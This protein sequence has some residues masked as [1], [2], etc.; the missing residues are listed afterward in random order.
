MRV[1][2]ICLSYGQPAP[3][4][5]LGETH[6]VPPTVA[7]L[8]AA[9]MAIVT[10][11]NAAVTVAPSAQVAASTHGSPALLSSRFPAAV[12]F[13]DSAL[14]QPNP[15]FV[16]ALLAGPGDVWHAGLCLGMSGLP[17]IID[18]VDPVWRFNRDPRPDA[19]AVSW[20][21]SLRAC[22]VRAEVVRRLG[23]PDPAFDTLTGA[24]LEMGHR[25]IG[26]GAMMRH[27]PG[28]LPVTV[29]A[30][31]SLDLT[32]ADEFRFVR[33][34]Y[35]RVW[36]AWAA[37]RAVGHGASPIET[38]RTWRAAP[39]AA[40]P[41][42]T[43]HS[44]LA[45][46]SPFA[47]EDANSAPGYAPF[48]SEDANSASGYTPFASEDAN[49]AVLH[50]VDGVGH[51]PLATR[52]SPPATPALRPLTVTVLIPTLDRYPHLFNLLDQL[53]GQSVP[54]LEI[55][56]VD[57]TAATERDITWPAR[58]TDLPL[59]V[60]WRDTAGQ[61]SSRNAGL[62]VA[63]GDAILFLD[64]DD[65][66]PPDLIARHLAYLARFGVDASCGVA[67]ELG[68]GALPAAFGLVRDSDVFPTNNALLRRAAL[69][70]SGLF[71]LAYE[72]GER[73]DGDLGMRL[74]LA[75]GALGLNPGAS[76]LHLHAP[77]GG[78]RQHR[79]RVVTRGGS[80][81]SLTGRHL[82][83]PTEGYYWSRYFTSRQRHE[84]L[85]I[86]TVSTL[87]GD[88]SRSRRLLRAGLMLLWLPDTWR[89][90]RARLAQGRAMLDR[91]PSIPAYD[92]A[93]V[94]EFIPT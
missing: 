49:S 93:A 55:I 73:A 60:I 3:A 53:R 48:A 75:G 52:H 85:L 72:R 70:G 58:F 45:L 69:T 50:A 82:L 41:P 80:R 18:F 91:F 12:L 20:R 35:G 90:N 16:A 4:W 78:L 66:I 6:L 15:D 19:P 62:A 88:G 47:S 86:R 59:R 42:A 25:W 22:L 40:A 92:P 31:V 5:P 27:V 51:S 2:L 30:S 61:C 24:A 83:A 37:W 54:P 29:E 10:P 77:R 23:G 56:V 36:A 14:G 13:W 1:D 21:L 71:D 7:T 94:E 39:A 32:L 64:D 8:A 84:A 17:G 28:L 57:Q 43:R 67:E 46:H 44:P 33:R 89:Q 74:Y 63:R 38:L 65:E 76:V 34:R 79:A 9:T 81:G 68:A 87:R 26:R 11:A